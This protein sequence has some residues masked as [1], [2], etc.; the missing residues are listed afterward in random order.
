MCKPENE[1]NINFYCELVELAA[2]ESKVVP[3]FPAIAAEW[4]R[5]FRTLELRRSR[6][7]FPV[8]RL[9]RAVTRLFR[10]PRLQSGQGRVTTAIRMATTADRRQGRL[11]LRMFWLGVGNFL[12]KRWKKRHRLVLLAQ[13]NPTQA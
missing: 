13:T 7:P 11:L 12:N 1:T 6:G 3:A 10:Q 8:A 4:P 9:R 5:T 2:C